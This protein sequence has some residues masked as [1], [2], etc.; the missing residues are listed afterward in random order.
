[1]VKVNIKERNFLIKIL[2]FGKCYILQRLMASGKSLTSN[3]LLCHDVHIVHLGL[4]MVR[5]DVPCASND[6]SSK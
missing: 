2:K 4:I 3:L 5:V 6:T 1:M